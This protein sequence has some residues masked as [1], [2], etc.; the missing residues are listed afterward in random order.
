VISWFLKI[1]FFKWVN[2]YRYI[3][4]ACSD[5]TLLCELV[6]MLERKELPG[7]TWQPRAVA[8]RL[9][10]I[11]KA[12]E[13]L[14]EQ[15][16]MSPMNLWCEKDVLKRDVGVVLGLLRDMHACSAY[17]KFSRVQR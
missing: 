1:C 16:A 3:A 2:L 8:S 14:R 4:A 15:P 11:G 9:H 12:L 6:G 7:V 10:N 13:K 5:G 17:R